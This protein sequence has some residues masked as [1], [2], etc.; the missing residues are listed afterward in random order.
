MWRQDPPSIPQLTVP[1]SV[2][3][4]CQRKAYAAKDIEA[5]AAAYLALVAFY[6]LLSVGE[7]MLPR[8]V[9]CTEVWK[10]VTCT[11]TLRIGNMGCNKDGK[12]LARNPPITMLLQEDAAML[13][14]N[15]PPSSHQQTALSNQ[16]TCKARASRAQTWKN[17]RFP[18]VFVC[19]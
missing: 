10:Q 15:N 9:K 11:V 8:K 14:I 3:I 6:F 2:P 7:Y 5:Q 1:V 16:S 17:N 4:E 13:K 12:L 18:F 19:K